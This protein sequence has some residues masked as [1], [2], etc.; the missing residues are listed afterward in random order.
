MASRHQALG[1]TSHG[2]TTWWADD[3][4]RWKRAAARE[5]VASFPRAEAVWADDPAVGRFFA[6]PARPHAATN[7]RYRYWSAECTLSMLS[8]A[9]RPSC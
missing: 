8:A 6:P 4:A 9:W 7:R 2:E 1:S 3:A 5:L